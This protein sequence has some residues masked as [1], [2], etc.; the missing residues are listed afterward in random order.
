MSD[1][2]K[3][4]WIRFDTW[5]KVMNAEDAKYEFPCVYVLAEN[6]GTPM[7]I[8]STR[9][10]LHDLHG[11][12]RSGGL[13]SRY[14]QAWSV[15]DACMK[16]TGRT[17]YVALVERELAYGIE[18]QLTYDNKPEHNKQNKETPPKIRFNLVHTGSPP[19]FKEG[20]LR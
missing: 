4:I 11:K 13:R 10:R 16:G 6:D 18:R 14:K 12:P 19:V 3:L 15:L 1:I 9:S 20:P 8:G 7:Y 17:V 2:I 5:E